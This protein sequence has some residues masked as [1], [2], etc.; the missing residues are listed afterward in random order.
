MEYFRLDG[1]TVVPCGRDEW[2][3]MI[4]SGA[5]VV[6]QDL[7]GEVKL[8]TVLLGIDHAFGG[9][10]PQLFETMIFGGPHDEFQAR[11]ATYDEAVVKHEW[12]FEAL[13][14]GLSPL[15]DEEPG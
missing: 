12:I 8:S 14:K 10:M 5:Q 9:G 3:Q 4:Q 2:A 7:V 11:W 1:A 6:K 13:S 15:E